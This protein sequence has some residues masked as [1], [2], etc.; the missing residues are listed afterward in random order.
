MRFEDKSVAKLLATRSLWLHEVMESPVSALGPTGA[1]DDEVVKRRLAR[2]RNL[3]NRFDQDAFIRR[4][5]W[6][7]W[8]QEVGELEARLSPPTLREPPS[9]AKQ[10]CA[11]LMSA[12]DRTWL[13]EDNS[14]RPFSGL[15]DALA[16]E[17]IS[18]ASSRAVEFRLLFTE[19]ARTALGEALADRIATAI[20]PCLQVEFA[21][22]RK[23]ATSRDQK[24]THE[25]SLYTRFKLKIAR[26]RQLSF[27]IKYAAATRRVL[28]ICRNSE[29]SFVELA[30][31]VELDRETLY[32]FGFVSH[33]SVVV[34]TCVAGL[35]DPHDGGRTVVRCRFSC[36]AVLFYKPRG[37]TLEGRLGPLAEKIFGERGTGMVVRTLNFHDRAWSLAAPAAEP[38]PDVYF[39]GAGR[40]IA[41]SYAFG[42]SDLH[43]ENLLLGPSGPLLADGESAFV[44]P[45]RRDV[46]ANSS[47]VDTIESSVLRSGLLPE[48]RVFGDG[49][50]VQVAG[51]GSGRNSLK[52]FN[53]QQWRDVNS[54]KMRIET[55]RISDSDF[56]DN[57][58]AGYHA[59]YRP[60]DYVDSLMDG[61]VDGYR[62]IVDWWSMSGSRRDLDATIEGARSRVLVR[63][64][65][66]YCLLDQKLRSPRCAH[67]GIDAAIE[68]EPLT[69]A[70]ARSE[71]QPRSWPL[72]S[73]EIRSLLR[74]DIPHFVVPVEASYYQAE[75]GSSCELFQSS[76]GQR[77]RERL[78][79]F[80]D[81]D[82]SLQSQLVR[83]AFEASGAYGSNRG[84]TTP[85]VLLKPATKPVHAG[86]DLLDAV[87]RIAKTIRASAINQ[88]G[89]LV[90]VGVRRAGRS[91]RV[92]LKPLDLSL[93]DGVGGLAV[94]FAASGRALGEADFLDT[95][96]GILNAALDAAE[97]SKWSSDLDVEKGL[98]TGRT[99]FA[100]AL[101]LCGRLLEEH[102][103]VD[104]AC[105]LATPR[106]GAQADDRLGYAD[107]YGGALGELLVLHELG[108][109]RLA[110][111]AT[112]IA[113]LKAALGTTLGRR[114]PAVLKVPGPE[115]MGLA[116]G[117][118]GMCYALSQLKCA[119]PDLNSLH[120]D[121]AGCA[122]D[123]TAR[124]LSQDDRVDSWAHGPLGVA[125]A[126][127]RSATLSK[128]L[129][130]R[131]ADP[132]SAAMTDYMWDPPMF[133]LAGLIEADIAR[134][135]EAA[136]RQNACRLLDRANRAGRFSHPHRETLSLGLF[137]GIAGVAYSLLRVADPR[138][139]P[140]VLY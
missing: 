85:S 132:R 136:A 79:W 21:S 76:G 31:N 139:I 72:I 73:E 92:H 45:I 35:S 128:S 102:T 137:D 6:S 10:G 41:F 138:T 124:C 78:D 47:V 107:L 84:I 65:T 20:A 130:V 26:D 33:S 44:H 111:G 54:D 96:R 15:I 1:Q 52:S 71:E 49:Q 43:A 24:A 108:A 34:D 133:G 105:E 4:L 75:D 109:D 5:A 127:S 38:E 93:Y 77:T 98:A 121:V 8:P 63:D 2:W 131:G 97:V 18:Q 122:A 106:F 50:V 99:G 55:V 16:Q 94:F 123:A 129:V 112:R 62:C 17:S 125:F 95:A 66:L 82:L 59:K 39:R 13:G 117:W 37:R 126:A 32:R 110:D 115:E 51:L 42:V 23:Q 104:A 12:L 67:F 11:F 81:D 28:N 58:V 120:Y 87:C 53:A 140:P 100:R 7:G 60:Q 91:E 90:W 83:A 25:S 88:G 48:W 14:I 57:G 119:C 36:G 74:G 56:E 30:R 113:Y 68:L 61:F 116:H 3:V 29:D 70:L 19:S 64:T 134:G 101:A 86:E 89:V 135:D 118:S 22:F 27:F 46:H 69:A 80:G 40:L 103:L 9:W 114:A